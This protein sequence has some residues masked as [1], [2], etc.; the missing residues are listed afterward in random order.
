MPNLVIGLGLPHSSGLAPGSPLQPTTSQKSSYLL[1][2]FQSISDQQHDTQ[3]RSALLS[4]TSQG[5]RGWWG[6]VGGGVSESQMREPL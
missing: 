2:G 4:E 5:L 3:N 6:G 1:S